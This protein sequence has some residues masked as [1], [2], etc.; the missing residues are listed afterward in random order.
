[1]C[2]NSVSYILQW[3]PEGGRAAFLYSAPTD[4]T[5]KAE[6]QEVAAEVYSSVFIT[7][8]A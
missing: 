1:M 6:K 3:Q 8:P 2:S 4:F 5:A 7:K